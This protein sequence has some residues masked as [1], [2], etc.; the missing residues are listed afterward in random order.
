MFYVPMH[1][2]PVVFP[3]ILHLGIAPTQCVCMSGLH[4]RLCV[5]TCGCVCA[6]PVDNMCVCK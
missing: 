3:Q 5:H 2:A 6:G 4:T 1:A